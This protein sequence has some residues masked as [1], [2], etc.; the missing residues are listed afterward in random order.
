MTA[1]EC[2]ERITEVLSRDITISEGPEFLDAISVDGSSTTIIAAPGG[3]DAID[4]LMDISSIIKEYKKE[5]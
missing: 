3:T 4:R 5:V 2:I 1:E